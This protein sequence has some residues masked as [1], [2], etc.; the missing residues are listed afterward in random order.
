MGL[1]SRAGGGAGRKTLQ[2]PTRNGEGWCRR[3]EGE[4]GGK[5]KR[6]KER[7]GEKEREHLKHPPVTTAAHDEAVFARGEVE[8]DWHGN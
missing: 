3:G 8:V 7:E 6:E 4:E 1:G 2:A 5:R